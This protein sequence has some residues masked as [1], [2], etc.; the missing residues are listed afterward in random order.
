MRARNSYMQEKLEWFYHD[1]DRIKGQASTTFHYHVENTTKSPAAT[2]I[3]SEKH[4]N[5]GVR[6]FI[7]H[8]V[9]AA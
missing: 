2:F 4:Q 5:V 6:Q 8:W 1:G 7:W 9:S 3:I